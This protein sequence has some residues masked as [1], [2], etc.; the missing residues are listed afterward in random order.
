MSSK[1]YKKIKL[2]DVVSISSS[3]R[4][5]HADYVNKGVPFYRSK[6][7]IEKSTG[8]SVSQKLYITKEKFNEIKEKFGAPVQ[9]DLL[10]TSVGTLGIPYVVKDEEF[11]FKDGNL[12]WFKDFT[13]LDVQYLY[14]FFCSE[15]GKERLNEIT[16]GSTQS[17]LTIAGLKSIEINLPPYKEQKSIAAILSSL[18]DK[19][20]LLREQN[21]T[22]ESIAQTI[23]KEW[24]VDFNFPNGNGKPYKDNGGEMVES[25]F[26]TTPK[27][28]NINA[29]GEY[30][31]IC[32]GSTPSTKNPEFWDGEYNWTSPKDLSGTSNIYLADTSKTI[33]KEGLSKISSGLL[34]PGTLL[35]SSRAPIGYLAITTI[36]VAINQG[37]IAIL[38]D[39]KLPISFMF[40]WLKV[41]ME[42][43]ISSANGSTFLEISKSSFRT[44]RTPI[45]DQKTLDKFTE[46][47]GPIMQKIAANEKQNTTLSKIRD[48]FLPKLI[49]G[50]IKID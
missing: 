2:S 24:F 49:N 37:Y 13:G 15:T 29:L 50:V 17:A 14:Y 22:L 19:I 25:E 20:E 8:N 9:G 16:I 23:F 10:L 12:T 31:E 5:F 6:E 35:L 1:N 27:E 38:S 47:I 33:T 44:I 46:V 39:S 30:L 48:E 28:W 21:K 26:G 45:P 4:I 40:L 32:G 43:V 7:I 18:D 36:P 42:K 3:K 41:Y 11:Y 34:D